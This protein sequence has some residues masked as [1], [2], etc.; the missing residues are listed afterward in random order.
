MAKHCRTLFPIMSKKLVTLNSLADAKKITEVLRQ[1]P[2]DDV[3]RA[4]VV[5]STTASSWPFLVGAKYPEWIVEKADTWKE[6]EILAVRRYFALSNIYLTAH[7]PSEWS[8]R[9]VPNCK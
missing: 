7:V 8:S 4:K 2:G 3:L 1:N 5:N 6:N 9:M